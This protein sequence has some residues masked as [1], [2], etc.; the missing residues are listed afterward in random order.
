MALVLF[1]RLCLA[2]FRSQSGAKWHDEKEACSIVSP[3]Q[4]QCRVL[5]VAKAIDRFALLI[6]L[7]GAAMTAI[8][9]A[10]EVSGAFEVTLNGRLVYSRLRVGGALPDPSQL[11]G[12]IAARVRPKS[13]H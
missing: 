1:A 9:A 8:G 2:L 10:S 12:L 11:A 6:F 3:A 4:R 5:H 13:G 7:L